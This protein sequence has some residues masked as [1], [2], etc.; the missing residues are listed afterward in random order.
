MLRKG[1]NKGKGSLVPPRGSHGLLVTCEPH[2]SQVAVEQTLKLCESF[3][4]AQAARAGAEELSLEEEL[5]Q[6]RGVSRKSRFI[7]YVSDV[8][9]NIFIRFVDEQD[10]PFAV[11]ERYFQSIRESRRSET[12]HVTRLYPILASG[13]PDSE[14][15]LPVLQALLP[16][17]FTGDEPVTYEI[18]IQRKHKGD[19]QKESHDELNKRIMESVGPPHRAMYHGG[20][21]AVLWLSLGRNLY[22]SV[23]PRWKEWCFCNVPKFCAHLDIDQTDG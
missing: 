22:M 10:D 8:G 9:G 14:E 3:L 18:V 6:V 5:A 19:G 7:P 15:S 4:P 20:D 16:R 1:E 17:F 11:V 21:S 13:F 2:Q 12:T 23:V